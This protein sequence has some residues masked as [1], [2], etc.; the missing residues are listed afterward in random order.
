MPTAS[1]NPPRD[2]RVPSCTAQPMLV[3]KPLSPD[4]PGDRT[5]GSRGTWSHSGLPSPA[6][7]WKLDLDVE[8]PSPPPPSLSSPVPDVGSSVGAASAKVSRGWE[9]HGL[10][11]PLFSLRPTVPRCAHSHPCP[12]A[13]QHSQ[14]F[15]SPGPLASW[16]AVL[17]SGPASLPHVR[18]V[19]AV[20]WRGLVT[21]LFL[22]AGHPEAPFPHRPQAACFSHH[23]WDRQRMANLL[24]PRS[25]PADEA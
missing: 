25:L 10:I 13:V 1:P 14:T 24:P 19:A 23:A 22:W 7:P 8:G 17:G 12:P 21:A 16:W 4:K 5:P 9:G 15:F 18:S 2:P 3:S 20:L 11:C 6:S